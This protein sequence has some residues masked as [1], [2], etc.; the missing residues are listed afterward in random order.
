MN[1]ATYDSIVNRQ[2]VDALKE[3]IFKRARERAEAFDAEIK[4]SYTTS[5]QNEV[6]D[7]ARNT[8]VSAKNPFSAVDS[9]TKTTEKP[10]EVLDVEE[11]EKPHTEVLSEVDGL[12]FEQRKAESM[13]AHISFSAADRIKN[14]TL[15]ENMV[16]ARG[17]F[18]SKSTFMGALNFLNSQASIALVRS[19][20]KA[21]DAIA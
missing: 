20:G 12:G 4:D 9:F 2:E 18:S 8:F 11:V 5:M 10:V 7:L 6:M 1:T 14:S 17:E 3:M 21:F 13:R 19:K 15:E 16:E